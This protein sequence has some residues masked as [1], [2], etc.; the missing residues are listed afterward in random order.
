METRNIGDVSLPAYEQVIDIK[1]MTIEQLREAKSTCDTA[2]I[3]V[4]AHRQA[5]TDEIGKRKAAEGMPIQV[6][7][8]ELKTLESVRNNAIRLGLEPSL[9]TGFWNNLLEAARRRQYDYRRN[10]GTIVVK[11]QQVK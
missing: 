1:E 8:E 6:H 7:S 4:I 3:E 9:I 10:I 2:I 11:K 5:I